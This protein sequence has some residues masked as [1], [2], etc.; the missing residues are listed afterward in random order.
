L[1]EMRQM[2]QLV[3][4]LDEGAHA[5]SNNQRQVLET[6]LMKLE[7]NTKTLF[8]FHRTKSIVYTQLYAD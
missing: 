8:S 7:K 5:I 3:G 4:D 1:K 2:S 6:L